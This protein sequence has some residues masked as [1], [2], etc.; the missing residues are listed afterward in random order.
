MHGVEVGYPAASEAVSQRAHLTVKESLS[1]GKSKYGLKGVE[2]QD[3]FAKMFASRHRAE[4]ANAWGGIQISSHKI[5]WEGV[6][7]V[8]ERAMVVG[9]WGKEERTR[10]LLKVRAS[11]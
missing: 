9:G 8:A 6:L 2:S 1:A 5:L 7:T 4:A 11:C 3:I 10:K